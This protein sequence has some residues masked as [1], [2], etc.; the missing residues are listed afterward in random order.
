MI[1]SPGEPFFG[2]LT[3]PGSMVEQLPWQSVSRQSP[4]LTFSV[5]PYVT[6]GCPQIKARFLTHTM[7]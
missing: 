6:S 7:P 5:Q 3:D 2:L 1:S 4:L